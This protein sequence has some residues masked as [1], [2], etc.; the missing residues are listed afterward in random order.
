MKEVA[1]LGASLRAAG[2]SV[3]AVHG[4]NDALLPLEGPGGA[5]ELAAALG[6]QEEPQEKSQGEG[7]VGTGTGTGTCTGTGSG[8]C[9]VVLRGC[10]HSFLLERPAE[11]LRVI[12]RACAEASMEASG[13]R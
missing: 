10:S 2:C 5:R 8:G 7:A 1:S 4:S 12:Y 3:W 9:L 13:S 6:L 11:T